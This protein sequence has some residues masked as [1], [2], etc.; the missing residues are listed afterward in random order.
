MPNLQFKIERGHKARAYMLNPKLPLDF[1]RPNP[2]IKKV[3][4]NQSD[5][6]N[7]AEREP[8]WAKPV[9]KGINV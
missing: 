3:R 6:R 1:P 4:P 5:L 8:D 7:G 2:Y 9:K